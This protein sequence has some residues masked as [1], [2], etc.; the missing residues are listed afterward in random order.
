MSLEVD[1]KPAAL[2]GA[3]IFVQTGKTELPDLDRW[4]QITEDEA[5]IAYEMTLRNELSGGT[6][7]VREFEE[8]WRRWIGTKYA[9]SVMNGTA[10]L[11][12][13]FFG[14]GVGPGDEVICPSYTWICTIS[15]ALMLGARPVFCESNPNTLLVDPDDIRRRITPRTKAIVVVH[16]WGF[17]CDMDAIMAISRE[18]GIPVV[19]D[20]AHAHGARYKGRMCGGIGHA[21]CWSLQGTKPLSGGEGGMMVTND[22]ECFERACL[23]GQVNRIKGVDLVTERYAEHQP[24]GLGI[25]F[26]SHPLGIGI[27]KVQLAK[28]PELN[29]RRRR[30]IEAVE[31][32]IRDLPGMR[33]VMQYEGAERAGFYD[34][35]L[36]YDAR[37]TGLSRDRFVD[38][39]RQEGLPA[40]TSPYPLLHTLPLF[41]NG[42]DIFT[43][44]RGP[45]C[46][47]YPGYREGDFPATE[48]MHRQLVFLPVLSD[49]VPEA[50]EFVV[51]AIRRVIAH[52]TELARAA[53]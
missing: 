40:R 46:G 44:N 8:E 22:T 29:R 14:L 33:P 47:D 43:R 34:F 1:G 16:L 42:F 28:L 52:A 41:A 13:A 17:V 32:G 12:S 49:P 15:P 6:P 48:R 51:A 38:A 39:V 36:I 23:I 21:G 5:R 26:R 50:A 37:Q 53:S 2:G 20:C 11:W 7:V 19:E 4:R 31:E 3:P 45:L 27:A 25:K 35:P 18:S 10:A 24:L 30:Y 9:L